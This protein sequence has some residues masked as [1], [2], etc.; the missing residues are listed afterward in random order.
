MVTVSATDK[1]VASPVRAKPLINIIPDNGRD[2]G[3]SFGGVP[4]VMGAHLMAS[5]FV[6]PMST[7]K[8]P[9]VDLV[10]HQFQ[11][12]S[13]EGDAS[14]VL[15]FSKAGLA[16][17]VVK[18]VLEA[19]DAAIAA[20]GSFTLVLSGGSLL[21]LLSGLVGK[22]EPAWDKWHIFY[23]DERNVPYT[24]PDSTHKAATEILLSKV[25]IPAANI[26]AILEGVPVEQAA[27]NYE[28]RLIGLPTSVLPRAANGFPVF[29]LILL[30]MGPDGHV[31]SLFPNRSQTAATH[32]WILP[33]TA[34][35]KPPP[36][37]I[38]FTMPVINAAKDIVLVAAG[39]EKAEIVQRALEI[40]ALPGS[41][42]AQ[43]VRPAEGRLR[44]FL[45]VQSAQHLNIT[46]WENK[47]AWPRSQ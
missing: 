36:E 5:G 11:Y 47:K 16:Q 2:A 6:A 15:F 37:R 22:K 34:S 20:K 8:G 30:G 43:L 28:G 18:A 26:Y 17:G 35:P 21:N 38:T 32:G 9:G 29:D 41:L 25:P 14:I 10:P 23:V 1:E 27:I 44:W 40:Q 46:E 33:V 4:P 24:S 45:D 42:P 19:A 31:A 3:R 12:T 7:S 13:I 39:D